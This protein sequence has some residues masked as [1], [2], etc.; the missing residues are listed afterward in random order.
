MPSGENVHKVIEPG[1]FRRWENVLGLQLIFY[2]LMALFQ[3]LC[4]EPLWNL[5][6]RG[7]GRGVYPYLPS[8]GHDNHPWS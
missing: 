5:G 2:K 8:S 1:M 4:S 3:D 6:F 7:F